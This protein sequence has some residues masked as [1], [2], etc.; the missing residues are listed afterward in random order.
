MFKA[1]LWPSPGR[2]V[3]LSNAFFADDDGLTVPMFTDGNFKRIEAYPT[4]RRRHRLSTRSI[5]TWQATRI[6]YDPVFLLSR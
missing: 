1:G 2:C 3:R 4:L 6:M 5:A